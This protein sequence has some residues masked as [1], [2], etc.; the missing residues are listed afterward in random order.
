MSEEIFVTENAQETQRLGEKIGY[1]IKSGLPAQ[2]GKIFALFGE[3]GSGKTTFVQGL[4]RGLGIKRRIISPTFIII[5][6]YELESGNFYHVD[7][8]RVEKEE[9]GGLELLEIINEPN[10]IIAIEWAEEIRIFLPRRRWEIYFEYLDENKR[11]IWI[12]KF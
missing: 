2:A 1:E 11:K 3:L 7:L 8:Y 5:R 9:I 10:S 6:K 4:A 12:K